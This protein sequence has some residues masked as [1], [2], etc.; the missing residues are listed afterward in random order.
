MW[1]DWILSRESVG[2][3]SHQDVWNHLYTKANAQAMDLW[4][5]CISL[6]VYMWVHVYLCMSV[7]MYECVHE[8]MCTCV[9]LCLCLCMFKFVCIYVCVCECAGVLMSIHVSV[10]LCVFS[11]NVHECDKKN[12]LFWSQMW[13]II[14]QEHGIRL[15]QI[16]C[17]NAEAVLWTFYSS[18]TN[19]K[20]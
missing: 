16:P 4:C 15:L 10:H 5:V 6:H 11:W 8:C 19:K 13:M 9:H 1:S 12:S 14:S 3:I 20:S 7:C 17:Y 18:R 2:G